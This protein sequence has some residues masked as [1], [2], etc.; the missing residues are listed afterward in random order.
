[1]IIRERYVGNDLPRDFLKIVADIEQNILATGCEL[2]IDC[3]EELIADGS[4]GK[5]LWGA[6]VYLDKQ[7][8]DFVSLI[9]IRPKDGNRTME[10]VIP[11]IK[12]KV[13]EIIHRILL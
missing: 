9:N 10:I 7:K 3:A 1:M 13:Q 4:D 12:E 6:N 11:E 2:H 8:I 5:N